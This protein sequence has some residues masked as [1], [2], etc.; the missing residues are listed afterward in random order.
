MVIGYF[1]KLIFSLPYPFFSL[2]PLAFGTM[3]VATTIVTHV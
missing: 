3:P 1:E 2:M